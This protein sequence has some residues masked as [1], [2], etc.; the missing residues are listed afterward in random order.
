MINIAG[1][2]FSITDIGKV[3]A[4]NED[5]AGKRLNPYGQIMMV[6]CDGMG[7]R[8]KGDFASNYLGNSLLDA[9]SD[10][11]KP[12]KKPGATE[13]WLY[14]VINKANRD[15]YNKAQGEEEFK[16][17]GTTLTVVILY[18]GHLT[19][20]QVGD[21]RL[22]AFKDDELKQITVD[23]TYVKYLE[24]AHKISEKDLTSHPERH[25]LTNA[26]GTK[27][28]A[29]VDINTIPYKNER[30]LLCSDGLYNN[31]PVS[32]LKSVMKSHE[33]LERKAKQLIAFANA[34]GGSDNMA[35]VLWES[36]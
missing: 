11:E 19:Y 6:V 29:N 30:L 2:V 33:L 12:L 17:M 15:I 32:D 26:I 23:Q 8:N 24:H 13:K 3:R 4:A 31:L 25:K 36:N 7:G 22:Y 9:F 10:L 21:S 14:Q 5:F 34:N 18:E 1:N 28:N 20:A 16:N 27:Y 35:I